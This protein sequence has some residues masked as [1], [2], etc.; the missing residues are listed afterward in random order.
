MIDF[1]THILPGI[2]DGSRDVDMSM[3]M[4]REEQSQGIH[5]IIATPHFYANRRSINQFLERRQHA[6][7]K[8]QTALEKEGKSRTSLDSTEGK[9][10]L[11]QILTGAEVYYFAGMGRA[12]QLPQLCIE[13]TD[14]ILIEMP[15][16]QWREDQFRDLK[17]I[18][19]KQHLTVVLAHIERY[20]EF[21]KSMRV[22]DSILELPVIPQLNTGNF[23]K[24]DSFFS[25]NK[26][27]RFCLQMLKDHSEVLLGSDC[28]NLT[29][30]VPNLAAG[31]A[32]IA[33]E[34]GEEVLHKSDRTADRLLSA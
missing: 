13:G 31:R 11:P 30:R 12:D 32:V 20:P 10:R 15:F 25:R 23:L 1:H 5:T 7:E 33:K 27:R 24:K 4:L 29:S 19:E 22:W 21:Q 28:H 9:S 17:T 2:D 6:F 3:A 14:T 26:K 34:L 18:I 16:D 8:L